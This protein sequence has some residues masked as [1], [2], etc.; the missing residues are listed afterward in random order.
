MAGVAT[1]RGNTNH[2]FFR[3]AKQAGVTSAST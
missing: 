2:F 1:A 3:A